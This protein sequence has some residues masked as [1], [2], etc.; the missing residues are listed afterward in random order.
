MFS[1]ITFE[2]W[3]YGFIVFAIVMFAFAV[4]ISIAKRVNIQSEKIARKI[5]TGSSTVEKEKGFLDKFMD[6]LEYELKEAEIKIDARTFVLIVAALTIVVYIVMYYVSGTFIVPIALL[7]FPLYFAPTILIDLKSA[8]VMDKFNQELLLVL[9]RMAAITKNDSVLNALTE[10]K[11]YPA[12]SQKMRFTLNKVY[13]LFDYGGSIED[14]F[15]EV[16]KEVPSKDFKRVSTSISVDKAL[17]SNL[18][19]S[20]QRIAANISDDT[21]KKKKARAVLASASSTAKFLSIAPYG[22]V[23]GMMMFTDMFDEYLLT[24]PH[25]I[26]FTGILAFMGVGVFVVNNMVR[27]KNIK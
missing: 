1:S 18:S 8:K 20:L 17:G 26:I 11:D 23:C 14:S 21:V 6:N 15:A 9:R 2:T 16:A 19:D 3:S 22:L 25:Q 27:E 7:P 5:Q 13:S 24:V 10:V 4:C 12:Y